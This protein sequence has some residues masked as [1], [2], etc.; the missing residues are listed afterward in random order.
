MLILTDTLQ[1]KEKLS[2]QSIYLQL[3]L[4]QL[5]RQSIYY[6]INSTETIIFLDLLVIDHLISASVTLAY[7]PLLFK[8]LNSLPYFIQSLN[9]YNLLPGVVSKNSWMS[10][11]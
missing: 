2:K 9:K 11:K 1:I 3:G 4:T 5:I 10:G 8:H 7:L 6:S